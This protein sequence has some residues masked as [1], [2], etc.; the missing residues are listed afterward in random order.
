MLR[1][2][3]SDPPVRPSPRTRRSLKLTIGSLNPPSPSV[4]H[5]AMANTAS[6]AAA[7]FVLRLVIL[8]IFLAPLFP[9]AILSPGLLWFPTNLSSGVLNC[10][11]SFDRRAQLCHPLVTARWTLLPSDQPTIGGVSRL[12][13]RIQRVQARRRRCRATPPAGTLAGCMPLA[14]CGHTGTPRYTPTP[15][16]GGSAR[17]GCALEP[18]LP[19]SRARH[20]A[21]H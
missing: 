7:S 2:A 20:R 15:S 14:R 3:S 13:S 12:P 11:K 6:A 17:S 16:S 21:Q 19:G 9:P 5:P 18:A 1:Y 4:A 10:R 8:L